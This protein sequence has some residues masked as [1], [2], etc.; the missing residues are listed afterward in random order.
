MIK[1][2]ELQDNSKLQTPNSKPNFPYLFSM[3]GKIFLTLCLLL[4]ISRAG[5]QQFGAFPPSTRWQQ[6]NTD[7]A[8]V[9]F[10]NKI[11]QQAG[12]VDAII[13]AGAV[14]NWIRFRETW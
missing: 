8:R 14:V 13:H 1:R 6:I 2:Y 10:D 4:S 7:T 9:I 5:A 3:N 11:N 12:S